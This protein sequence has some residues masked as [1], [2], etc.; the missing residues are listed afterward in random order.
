MCELIPEVAS[1]HLPACHTKTRSRGINLIVCVDNCGIKCHFREE[2]V[3][4]I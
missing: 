1:E 4:K 3:C 2:T